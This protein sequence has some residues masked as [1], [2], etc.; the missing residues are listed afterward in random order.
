MMGPWKAFACRNEFRAA[1]GNF[2]ILEL[3]SLN[4][5]K[6]TLAAVVIALSAA[7]FG[8]VAVAEEA[9]AAAKVSAANPAQTVVSHIEM[10]LT[11]LD[12]KGDL[13]NA[14]PH[15]KT[16]LEAARGVTGDPALVKQAWDKLVNGRIETKRGNPGNAIKSLNEAI[17]LYKSL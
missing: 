3:N 13:S 1:P 15:I 8:Q 4:I 7:S 2:N 9:V 5:I 11:F 10:A 16:A 6:N 14:Q 12:G 17:K